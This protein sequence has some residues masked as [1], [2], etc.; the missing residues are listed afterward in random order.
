MFIIFSI[1]SS[2]SCIAF[3]DKLFIEYELMEFSSEITS[4]GVLYPSP[5][6]NPML[7]ALE[8]FL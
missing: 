8:L 4:L 1:F 2:N 5:I 3:H 7:L 6:I